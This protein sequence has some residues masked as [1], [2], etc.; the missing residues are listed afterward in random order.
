MINTKS[1]WSIQRSSSWATN[2]WNG[3]IPTMGH[4]YILRIYFI[5]W[6]SRTL[7]CRNGRPNLR[8][9][10]HHFHA[11]YSQQISSHMGRNLLTVLGMGKDWA[12]RTNIFSPMDYKYRCCAI[13]DDHNRFSYEVKLPL[14]P[15]ILQLQRHLLGLTLRTTVWRRQN[16]LI[17]GAT[18]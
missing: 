11:L 10:W 14:Q 3:G 9:I 13:C 16:Q 17:D 15:A 12:Q 4:Y 8:K 2:Y 18:M 7:N 6:L 1:Q 5:S